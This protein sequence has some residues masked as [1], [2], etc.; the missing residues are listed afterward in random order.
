M[1]NNAAEIRAQC[2]ANSEKL[3]TVAERELPNGVE[4]I[5]FHLALLALE[6]I[7]KGILA[8]A[9]FTASRA[10]KDSTSL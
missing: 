3:L 4:H 2:I 1:V 10:G 7:G 9:T 8:T 6:E 5:C